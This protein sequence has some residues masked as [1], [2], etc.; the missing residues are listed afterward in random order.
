[1]KLI[2]LPLF[3]GICNRLIPIASALRL[4][5]KTGRKVMVF[6]TDNPGRSL[7]TYHGQSTNFE[8]IFEPI[9]N[10][11]F[12]SMVQI[13]EYLDTSDHYDCHV[14]V[15]F[16]IVNT[17]TDK[18]I[19]VVYCVNTIFSKDDEINQQYVLKDIGKFIEDS[20]FMEMKS[21]LRELCPVTH[22]KNEID[23]IY[24]T[25]MKG[26]IMVGL[27]IRRTDGSFKEKDWKK[28]DQTL[29]LR[30]RSWAHE[31][32]VFFLATD[33][34]RHEHDFKMA[35]GNSLITYEP[36]FNKFGN[37]RNNV[38]AAVVDLYLLS[39]CD[40]AIIGTVESSFSL[41]AALLSEK[42]PLWMISENCN[43][44]FKIHI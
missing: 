35:L 10:M 25:K 33:S 32:Y 44:V 11:E 15:P 43:S 26:R 31:G 12:L 17:N 30:A 40:R 22:L 7:L 39:K 16:P 9:E 24:E 19:F 36:R 34:P 5:K 42:T 13:N 3:N 37:D 20:V 29:L 23:K 4:A 27:H 41:T 1:M 28:T 14:L 21:V 18:H 8:D 2:C 6:W 38:L